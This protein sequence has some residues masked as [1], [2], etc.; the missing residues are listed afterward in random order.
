[1]HSACQR[2]CFWWITRTWLSPLPRLSNPLFLVELLSMLLSPLICFLPL[3]RSSHLKLFPPRESWESPGSEDSR[4]FRRTF[5]IPKPQNL[6]CPHTSWPHRRC[7]EET[8]PS[9][10][11][12][13]M[14]LPNW[15]RPCLPTGKPVTSH[16]A[17][18]RRPSL[19]G[20]SSTFLNNS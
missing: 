1:M 17:L 7:S 2:N 19:V 13:C 6:R 3:P 14:V 4:W 12:H 20:S 10:S 8:V 18:I 16:R 15:M 9:T 11:Y 5:P